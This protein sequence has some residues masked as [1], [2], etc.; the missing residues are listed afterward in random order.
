MKRKQQENP[1][2]QLQFAAIFGF[3]ATKYTFRLRIMCEHIFSRNNVRINFY[4]TQKICSNSFNQ[5]KCV[6]KI[7]NENAQ[8]F[9]WIVNCTVTKS[10]VCRA[11]FGGISILFAFLSETNIGRAC[12]N[13]K[14]FFPPKPAANFRL[15][16][17]KKFIL[18]SFV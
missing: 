4:G 2:M 5:M 15:E 16:I 13:V 10:H 7:F 9:K 14:V 3:A 18:I 17:K 6:L 1:Q 12:A 8:T 11:I